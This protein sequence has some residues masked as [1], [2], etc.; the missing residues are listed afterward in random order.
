M[1]RVSNFIIAD[2]KRVILCSI[3]INLIMTLMCRDPLLKQCGGSVIQ[4][5]M[6]AC[7]MH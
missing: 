3:S 7:F 6:F 2:R 4:F 1:N 5:M